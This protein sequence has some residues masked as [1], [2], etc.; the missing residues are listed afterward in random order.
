M[1]NNTNIYDI[2]DELIRKA[3]DNHEFTIQEVQEKLKHYR[4]RLEEE[5]QRED[6]DPR[7]IASYNTY[8]RNLSNYLAIKI[9]QLSSNE[10]ADLIRVNN[11]KKTTTEEVEKALNDTK[12]G[13]DT[14][15]EIQDSDST[16]EENNRDEK[17]GN[18]DT[19]GRGDSDIHEERPVTQEDLLV[20]RGEV[21]DKM[22]EYVEFEEV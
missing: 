9:S 5:Q 18:D 12:T 20:E 19:I 21:T 1:K 15:N 17:P 16:V 10:I 4:E 6:A 14:E 7:R 2:D 13:G 8:I 11:L 3:G 22:D